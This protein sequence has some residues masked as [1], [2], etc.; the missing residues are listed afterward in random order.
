MLQP[1]KTSE[2]IT[3]WYLK[4][5]SADVMIDPSDMKAVED[6]NTSNRITKETIAT[7]DIGDDVRTDQDHQTGVA[8]GRTKIPYCTL[9]TYTIHNYLCSVESQV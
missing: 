6:L 3:I 7:T 9:I 2:V 5:P 8:G 4:I 1:R